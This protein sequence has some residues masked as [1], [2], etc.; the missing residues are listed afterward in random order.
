MPKSCQR[1][2]ESVEHEKIM[3]IKIEVGALIA[4]YIG[5]INTALK[6]CY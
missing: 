6:I 2:E 5:R 4:K 3:E 1:T